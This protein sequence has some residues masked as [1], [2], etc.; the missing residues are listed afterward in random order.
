M[1]AILWRAASNLGYP[2][3]P[4]SP[5]LHIRDPVA[6]AVVAVGSTE[7]QEFEDFV[8]GSR[9]FAEKLNA[10]GAHAELIIVDGKGHADTA[11]ALSDEQ[12]METSAVIR[13]ITGTAS[14]AQ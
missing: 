1:N 14:N 9:A 11:L 12:N 5:I 3:E 10:A 4:A 13:M 7:H 2:F 8:A 6:N